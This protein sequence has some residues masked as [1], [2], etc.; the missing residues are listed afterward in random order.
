[1]NHYLAFGIVICYPL[2]LT[3][4]TPLPLN[5]VKASRY[6]SDTS[7]QY[8]Q[9]EKSAKKGFT[10]VSLQNFPLVYTVTPALTQEAKFGRQRITGI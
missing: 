7:S 6:F 9:S 5:A 2:R 8:P 1:M 4:A 3:K 10:S